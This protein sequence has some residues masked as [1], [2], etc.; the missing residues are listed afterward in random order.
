MEYAR[1][2][3]ITDLV[4]ARD[5]EAEVIARASRGDRSNLE[6][7]YRRHAGWVFGLC[8]RLAPAAS[9]KGESVSGDLNIALKDNPGAEYDLQSLN[10]NVESCGGPEAKHSKYGHG[11]RLAFTVGDAKAQVRLSSQRGSLSLCAE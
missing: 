2:L 6:Q 9:I 5:E 4:A 8:L 11:T 3:P 10:G 7:I 1:L